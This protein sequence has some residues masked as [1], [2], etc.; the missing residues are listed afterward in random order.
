M[1]VLFA[2]HKLDQPDGDKF[3]LY[4]SRYPYW[5]AA[6]PVTSAK[7]FLNAQHIHKVFEQY[8]HVLRDY[9]LDDMFTSIKQSV[10]IVDKV[11]YKKLVNGLKSVWK[12]VA[13]SD[14]PS[15]PEDQDKSY[16]VHT[17]FYHAAMGK[18]GVK[19]SAF[20]MKEE[21]DDWNKE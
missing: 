14:Q 19:I 17:R 11:D 2:I 15:V 9:E 20:A 6:D 7:R 8:D 18:S 4:T 13:G 12:F 21:S 1:L 3:T 10:K 16:R 5:L